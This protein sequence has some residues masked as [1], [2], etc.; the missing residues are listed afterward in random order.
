MCFLYFIIVKILIPDLTH[1]VFIIL[2]LTSVNLFFSLLDIHKEFNVAN[3]SMCIFFLSFSVLLV[4]IV[5]NF[6]MSI[7]GSIVEF[8]DVRLSGEVIKIAFI[9][10]SVGIEESTIAL[11]L[12]VLELSAVEIAIGLQEITITVHVISPELS[13]IEITI[14]E[15]KLTNAFQ[16]GFVSNLLDLTLVS[17]SISRNSLDISQLFR[18]WAKVSLLLLLDQAHTDF[19][20]AL[21]FAEVRTILVELFASLDVILLVWLAGWTEISFLS[22]EGIVQLVI[23]LF[24]R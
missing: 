11:D 19:S 20:R 9:V 14:I 7:F 12:I 4:W 16:N 5:G 6:I 22:N 24:L 13:H 3:V 23:I 1:K 18:T 21:L 17:T 15:L 8:S 10:I 2:Q